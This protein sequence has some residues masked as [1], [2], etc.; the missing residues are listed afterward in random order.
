MINRRI[1]LFTNLDCSPDIFLNGKYHF[2]EKFFGEFA[3]HAKGI[4]PGS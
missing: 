2:M 3:A 4:L 1:K